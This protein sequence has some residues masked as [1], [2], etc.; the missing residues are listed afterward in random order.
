MKK[1]YIQPNVEVLS[2]SSMECI[3]AASGTKSIE[4]VTPSSFY[5]TEGDFI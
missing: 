1:M 2:V 4:I 5:Y 3:C